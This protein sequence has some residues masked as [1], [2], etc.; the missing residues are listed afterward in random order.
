VGAKGI[1][2]SPTNLLF[3]RFFFFP[4][5]LRMRFLHLL[6]EEEKEKKGRKKENVDNEELTKNRR[7]HFSPPPPQQISM[8]S[9]CP[10]VSL[11]FL[12]FLFALV[13][14]HQRHK[15]CFFFPSFLQTMRPLYQKKQKG[16]ADR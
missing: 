11:F 15:S 6:S 12:P 10:A 9:H 8:G 13:V 16:G 14:P 3:M 4:F 5:F 1:Y 2:F 7:P